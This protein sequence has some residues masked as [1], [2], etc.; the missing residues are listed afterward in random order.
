[1]DATI[2]FKKNVQIISVGYTST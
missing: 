2:Q 1:M